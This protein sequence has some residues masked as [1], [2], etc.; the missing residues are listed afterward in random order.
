VKAQA[1]KT[2]ERL[3]V[4]EEV[5][6]SSNR[7]FGVTFAIVFTIV[8]LSPLIRGRSTRGWA[9]IVAAAF[10][11][12]ALALP[13]MLAPLSWFW[14]RF[15]LLLHA[16]ISPIIMGLVFYTTVTPIGLVRR[17]LGQDPLRLRFDRDAVTYWIERHPPGPA[18]DTMPRQF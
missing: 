10:L 15:G 5:S 9:L 8:A 16:C 18:P 13:R 7:S 4:D 3:V 11:L 14:L 2:H 17:L 1:G 6:G 12:A